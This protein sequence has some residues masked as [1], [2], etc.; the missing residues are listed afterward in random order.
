MEQEEKKLLDELKNFDMNNLYQKGSY[1]DFFIQNY[2]TQGYILKVRQNNKYDILF[3]LNQAQIK[4]LSDIPSHFFGFFGENSLKH[5]YES[6]GICFNR[7]LCKMPSKQILLLLNIKLKKFNIELNYDLKDIKKGKIKKE[8]EE[9]DIIESNIDNKKEKNE[10]DNKSD[11]KEKDLDDKKNKEIKD[12]SDN[13]INDNKMKLE[14]KSFKTNENNSSD[15]SNKKDI[16]NNNNELK[17]EYKKEH[18][19]NSKL[20]EKEKEQ[21]KSKNSEMVVSPLV[22][23]EAKTTESSISS[24]NNNC[25]ENSIINQNNENNNKKNTSINLDSEDKNKN[26]ESS[27]Q[28]QNF[29][30]LTKLDKNGNPVDISGYYIFQFLG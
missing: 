19:E 9:K 2:W 22:S 5:E 1:I 16:N 11:K 25:K 21:D 10:N 29:N 12:K 13:S 23:T 6:R 15:D 30:S 24:E 4:T 18:C 27:A 7:E 3:V 28:K 26:N 8:N 20:D 14:E 17:E